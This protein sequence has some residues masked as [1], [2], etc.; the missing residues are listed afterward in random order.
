MSAGP[1]LALP[2]GASPWAARRW[3][4][5]WSPPGDE[6]LAEEAAVALVFN[7]I[8]HTVMM[9]TPTDLEDFALGFT[10]TE[11]LLDSPSELYGIEVVPTDAGL[12]LQLE[13]SAACERR[14][15]ERRRT[16]AGRSGCGLCGAEPG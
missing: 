1:T 16:L 12:E 4:G 13:V 6:A 14:L 11:G 3:S 9:A 15:K 10:L 5:S 2:A 8:A 7:G